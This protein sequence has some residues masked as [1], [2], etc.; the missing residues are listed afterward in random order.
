MRNQ[1]KYS[2]TCFTYLSSVFPATAAKRRAS[3]SSAALRGRKGE[4]ER[5]ESTFQHL[6]RVNAYINEP[7]AFRRTASF[8]PF[9]MNKRL[10]AAVAVAV[11]VADVDAEFLEPLP[12]LQSKDAGV[13]QACNESIA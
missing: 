11:A 10:S 4:H 5:K 2:V 9:H 8:C 3:F 13:S 1:S 12:P 6:Q 7:A